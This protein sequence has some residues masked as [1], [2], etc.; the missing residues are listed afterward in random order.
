MEIKEYLLE[1]GKSPFREWYDSLDFA[2]QTKVDARLARVKAFGHLGDH[3]SLKE[4]V[5]EFRFQT[6]SGLRIYFGIDG[7]KL[8]LLLVG[9]NKSTQGRDIGKAKMYWRDYLERG[10]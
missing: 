4:G 9:G 2:L 7:K 10:R 8:I 6:H 5:F 3:K 1:S